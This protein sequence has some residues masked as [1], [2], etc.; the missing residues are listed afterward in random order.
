[1]LKSRSYFKISVFLFCLNFNIKAR[2]HKAESVKESG[3]VKFKCRL[4]ILQSN[5]LISGLTWSFDYL[6]LFCATGRN[7]I[8]GII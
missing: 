7:S 6:T 5:Q 8:H 3:V 1:M 2:L 4:E